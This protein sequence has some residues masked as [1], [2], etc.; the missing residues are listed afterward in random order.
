MRTHAA[1]H[2]TRSLTNPTP[3]PC[4]RMRPT[5]VKFLLRCYSKGHGGILADDMG[6]GKTVQVGDRKHEA[7]SVV[8]TGKGGSLPLPDDSWPPFTSFSS[9]CESRKPWLTIPP[10]QAISFCA[11]VLN[12]TGGSLDDLPRMANPPPAAGGGGAGGAAAAAAAAGSGAEGDEDDED[13]EGGGGA[14]LQA[15]WQRSPILVVC[16]TAVVTNWQEEFAMWGSFQVREG[17]S[18]CFHASRACCWCAPQLPT[19][20]NPIRSDLPLEQRSSSSTA[21]RRTLPMQPPRT[22]R[23]RCCS[24]R[25][26][27]CGRRRTGWRGWSCT[28]V[29]HM[30]NNGWLHAGSCGGF[31]RL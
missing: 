9:L 21:A 24:R 29:T 8:L 15:R 26:G 27:S 12:K 16:P 25:T 23:P 4:N 28:W 20:P 19:K 17:L 1:V 2:A 11:A 3:P 31:V 6:L 18:Q 14:A 13:E 30:T 22:G 10:R 7:G 5:Q